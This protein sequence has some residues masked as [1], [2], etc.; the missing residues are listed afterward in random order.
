M[1]K[2]IPYIIVALIAL[3]ISVQYLF[4]NKDFEKSITVFDYNESYEREKKEDFFKEKIVD[5]NDLKGESLEKYEKWKK[6][7]ENSGYQFTDFSKLKSSSTKFFKNASTIADNNYSYANGLITGNWDQ[8]NIVLFDDSGFRSDGSTYDPINKELF[9]VSTAG[10]LYKI[11]ED[12]PI[13]WS[14]RN[15]KKILLGDD[16]NGINLPDNS[17]RLLHQ[18]PNGP[19]EFSDD[20]GRTWVDANGALFQNSW[21]NKTV[22]TKTSTGRRIVAHGGSFVAGASHERLFI[23]TDY[24]LNYTESNLRFRKSDFLMSINKPHNSR[25]VYCFVVQKSTSKLFIYKMGENDSDFLLI[26]SPSQTIASLDSVLGAEFAN[27][28]NHFYISSG[29]NIYY[30]NDEGRTWS[31]KSTTNDRALMEMHPQEPNI[32]FKGFI[33]LYMSTDFGTTFRSNN[34]YLRSYYVWDLQHMKTYDEEDGGNFTFVGMDFGSYYTN[35]S[36]LW[37]S[38]TSVNSG[39]P[40]ILAYDAITSEKHNKIY[41]ANQDRG[42]QGFIDIPNNDEIYT[43]AREANTDVLRVSL[44]RD[45][46][47]VWFWYYYGTIGRASVTNGGNYSTVLRRDFFGNW[48]ATSMIPSPNINEDAMYIPAGGTKLNKFTYTGNNIVQ[49]FHPYSFSSAPISFN[50]SALN[51]N[52]WYV[53]LASGDFMYSNNGGNSFTKTSYTGQMPGQDNDYRKRRTVIKTSKT[54]ES[55]VYF[56]GKGNIFLISKDGGVTFTNHNNGLSVTR[57]MDFEASE[58]GKFIFAACEFEGG[59]VYSVADDKWFRMDG[60]HVPNV[61][62]TDV[63]YIESKKIIRF[64]T[65]GSGVLDFK[66]NDNSLSLDDNIFNK[67]ENVKAF[68]NPTTG[69]FNVTVG[70]LMNEVLVEV[71]T[72]NSKLVLTKKCKVIDGKIKINIE[73]NASG[74]YFAKIYLEKPISVKILKE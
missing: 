65:Y 20:E 22:V 30:S 34:H 39:S 12:K 2:K 48:W 52:R 13:K 3:F 5:F 10:H 35:N 17:F 29:S 36:K 47:S 61:Q 42:S 40:T 23:S 54:D 16:F 53:G 70:S 18:K 56:A 31:L 26:A 25:S 24:G 44:S 68:P 41:T 63:Q 43:A 59:W 51:T 60:A 21:N 66:I 37:N 1:K 46:E 45:E 67:L 69:V 58:D 71:Y 74:L 57:F 11:E 8:K 64:G 4:L 14:I 27:T 62:F 32:C 50:Y 38:W 73:N 49:T 55:T 72:S 33:D 6:E 19:M 7:I 28:F 15:Q 9:V